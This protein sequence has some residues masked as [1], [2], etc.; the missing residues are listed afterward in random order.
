MAVRI[1]ESLS[2]QP[3]SRATAMRQVICIRGHCSGRTLRCVYDIGKKKAASP[4]VIQRRGQA[5]NGMGM[6]LLWIGTRRSRR[7]RGDER[8]RWR[9]MFGLLTLGRPRRQRSQAALSA[10]LHETI[11]RIV[12]LFA[13]HPFIC[14][15]PGVRHSNARNA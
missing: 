2:L 9:R 7:H 12:A 6:L 5:T 4:T 15:Y 10:A 8:R 11:T 13:W 1:R 3:T 14:Q